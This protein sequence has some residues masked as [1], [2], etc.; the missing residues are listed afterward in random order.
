VKEWKQV[1]R[2][3]ELTIDPRAIPAWR[4]KAGIYALI[5]WLITIGLFIVSIFYTWVWI[6]GSIFGAL[7]LVETLFFVWLLPVM[8]WKRWRYQVTEDDIELYRGI[9]IIERTIIPMVRIQHVDTKQGP[10]FKKYGLSTVTFATAAG[11]HEI[12]ALDQQT[13]DELR[14]RIAEWARV[15]NEDV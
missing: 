10:I 15:S 11:S 8:R 14:D 13:A 12:P 7:S 6:P 5:S 9:W 1:E 4:M 3:P 2:L